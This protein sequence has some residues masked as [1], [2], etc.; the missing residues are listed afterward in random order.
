MLVLDYMYTWKT[1]A[2]PNLS[3]EMMLNVY[4]LFIFL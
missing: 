3:H 1:R 4:Q 2:V